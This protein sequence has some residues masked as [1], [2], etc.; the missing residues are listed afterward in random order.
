MA[1][2]TP[3]TI[4]AVANILIGW[5]QDVCIYCLDEFARPFD[6]DIFKIK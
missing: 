1:A 5:E 4:S 3:W 6:V 2:T